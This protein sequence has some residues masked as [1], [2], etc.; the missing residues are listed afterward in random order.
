MITDSEFYHWETDEAQTT[1]EIT[2]H[3]FID[4]E[5]PDDIYEVYL[6]D[7]TYAEIQEIESGMCW[8]VHA[9]GNGD[10]CNHK[11]QFD[12]IGYRQ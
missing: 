8:A 6:H 12:A 7:G 5:L 1:N 3:D 4:N 11:V 9:S 2:M 10:F